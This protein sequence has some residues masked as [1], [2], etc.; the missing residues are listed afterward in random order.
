M[1]TLCA[2]ASSYSH[3][4]PCLIFSQHSF[5]SVYVFSQIDISL[6]IRVSPKPLWLHLNYIYKDLISMLDHVLRIWVAMNLRGISVNLVYLQTHPSSIHSIY[7][8]YT[9]KYLFYLPSP[10]REREKKVGFFTKKTKKAPG[11]KSSEK[12][13]VDSPQFKNRHLSSREHNK[14]NSTCI[15]QSPLWPHTA[16]F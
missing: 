6:W 4:N 9:A 2:L 14:A 15:Q 10:K 7:S 16:I 3:S 5:F 1:G 13:H 11:K 12:G 8:T